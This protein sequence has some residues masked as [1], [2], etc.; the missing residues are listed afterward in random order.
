MIEVMHRGGNNMVINE[1]AV[2]QMLEEKYIGLEDGANRV[3]A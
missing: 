2:V 1:C 3:S